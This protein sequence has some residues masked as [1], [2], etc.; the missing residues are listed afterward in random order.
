MMALPAAVVQ[1]AHTHMVPQIGSCTM[2]VS[3]SPL[4]APKMVSSVNLTSLTPT[5]GR[6]CCLD[7][8]QVSNSL[9]LR[10]NAVGNALHCKQSFVSLF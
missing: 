5:T 6:Q 3:R 7:V 4:G 10:D 1:T 8:V 9:V 2:P